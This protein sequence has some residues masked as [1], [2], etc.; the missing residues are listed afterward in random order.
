MHIRRKKLLDKSLRECVGR[1]NVLSC[2]EIVLWFEQAAIALRGLT[3]P[4]AHT[5]YPPPPK[6]IHIHTLLPATQ[7]LIFEEDIIIIYHLSLKIKDHR[8]P[9][10]P[11]YSLWISSPTIYLIIPS[12]LWLSHHLYLNWKLCQTRSGQMHITF[13]CT[14][15]LAGFRRC[16]PR[17]SPTN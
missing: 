15:I 10:L 6:H 17:S 14:P 13:L 11:S 8:F 5:T 12:T 2:G 3:L 4:I 1:I 16:P 7:L 9:A